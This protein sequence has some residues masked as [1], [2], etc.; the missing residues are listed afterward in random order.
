MRA[1]ED[2]KGKSQAAAPRSALSGPTHPQQ[3]PW[4]G[5]IGSSVTP[6]LEELVELPEHVPEAWDSLTVQ[7]LSP[8]LHNLART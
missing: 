4:G 7:G 1:K 3:C 5:G 8:V 6:A 2:K